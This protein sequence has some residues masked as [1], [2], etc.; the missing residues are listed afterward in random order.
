MK[1][2]TS[3]LLS[4]FC[5]LTFA[6]VEVLFHPYDDTFS[7]I[8]ER[9]KTADETIDLALYNI[10]SSPKNPII[11]YL[12]S[13]A[14]QKRLSTGEIK[15]RMIFEG[16][17]SKEDNLKKMLELEKL[18]IDVKTL[19]SSKKMH[20][21]FAVIDGYRF[22]ASV[23][24]GSAN[25]SMSSLQNYNENIMFFD[26]EGEM[27]QSFQKE[28]NFLW[29]ISKEIGR[30]ALYQSIQFEKAV[31][32]LGSVTFNRDNFKVTRGRLGKKRG[33]LGF[34]LTQ[35]VVAAIDSAEG[36]LE[37][38]TTR[39]KLRP[40]YNA[41]VRA[42]KRGVQV[43][44]LVT[45]GE[46]D[47]ARERSKMT[48]PHCDNEFARE[49]SSGVNYVSL[50]AKDNFEGH[51]N[52]EVRLKF[53]H[54]KTSAYLNKQMHSKY[55]I[56][57]NKEVLSGSFNWSY[58]GE[59]NHIENLVR[60]NVEESKLTLAD[61]NKDF[62]FMWNQGRDGLSA[63]H[64]NISRAIKN[65]EKMDCSFGPMALEHKEIDGLLKRGRKFCN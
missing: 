62:D 30:K 52:I 12:S 38:A 21:K 33:A 60:I 27:A 20:H 9:L 2:I 22:D 51:K 42:A 16:Y 29:D 10:D 11:K 19:K 40:I 32:S 3:L 47:W 46:Y 39:L 36:E 5:V 1:L 55:F 63:L 15:V 56:V 37:I 54:L 34:T 61:F 44:V 48:V 57:D 49:C 59:F 58:S 26:E 23:I 50:L 53:F 45:M 28:F 25:W 14:F 7:A 41:L 6:R 43:K 64:E 65:K 31:G 18:G 4:L 35:K 13:A 8:V 17:A 24:T